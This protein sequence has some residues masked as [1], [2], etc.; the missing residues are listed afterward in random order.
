MEVKRNI[1][2]IIKKYPIIVGGILISILIGTLLMHK[3]WAG[4]Q[5]ANAT[6]NTEEM[7]RESTIEQFENPEDLVRYLLAAIQNKDMDLA[8][9]A[10]AIDERYLGM[11]F[12]DILKENGKFS[13]TSLIPPASSYWEYRPLSSVQLAEFYMDRYLECE[14]KISQY[15]NISVESVDI[16]NPKQQMLNESW[17][18]MKEF[19]SKWGADASCQLMALLKC[20]GEYKVMGFTLG[21]YYGYWKVFDIGAELLAQD[22]EKFI[23]TITKDEYAKIAGNIEVVDF[24]TSL[25]KKLLGE[26]DDEETETKPKKIKRPEEQIL[27]L[28]YFVVSASYGKTEKATISDFVLWLQKRDVAMAMSYSTVDNK[29]KSTE[30]ISEDILRY[31]SEFSKELTY[32]YYGLL[33]IKY[34]AEP[35]TLL[36]MG[37]SAADIFKELS[38][39]Q[40]P[41]MNIANIVQMRTDAGKGTNQYLAFYTFNQKIYMSGYTL[42]QYG[43]GWQIETL[44][45]ELAN[46]QPG[47]VREITEENYEEWIEYEEE[48]N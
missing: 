17:L 20:D 13:Y 9:R 18:E 8:L 14:E 47:E 38:P 31:Q 23:T 27:P 35:K 7:T 6:I 39:E 36:E 26:N 5:N 15:T 45:S 25:N 19:S 3:F 1:V 2:G 12:F 42:K 11:E 34:Q 33:G 48:N 46:L 29:V 22:N 37:K 10:C 40:V 43:E 4:R 16:V 44:S 28:N 21:K 32:F 30:K 24:I 41:Y